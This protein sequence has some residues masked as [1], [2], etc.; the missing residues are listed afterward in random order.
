MDVQGYLLTLF[1]LTLMVS[2]VQLKEKN[3]NKRK[4]AKSSH[5][6]LIEPFSGQR[7][8]LGVNKNLRGYNEGLLEVYRGGKWGLVCDDDWDDQDADVACRQLGFTSGAKRPLYRDTADQFQQDNSSF[9]P[10]NVQWDSS[11]FVLNNVQCLGNE[12][13]L[14]SCPYSTSTECQISEAVS[15]TCVM[16]NTTD[17]GESSSGEW[18]AGENSCYMIKPIHK[19]D[20]LKK[21]L[22]ECAGQNGES[23][24]ALIET[25]AEH[26]FVSNILS[27]HQKDIDRV[28]LSSKLSKKKGSVWKWQK[29]TRKQDGKKKWKGKMEKKLVKM[30]YKKWFPGWNPT[31]FGAEPSKSNG[32]YQCMTLSNKYKQP[33]QR[34]SPVGFYYFDSAPCKPDRREKS[35]FICETPRQHKYSQSIRAGEEECYTDNGE[36]YRGTTAVTKDGTPCTRWTLSNYANP[37]T[38]PEKGLGDHKF[39]RNPDGDKEPWCWVKVGTNDFGFCDITQCDE[40]PVTT[41]TEAPKDCPDEEFYCYNHVKSREYTTECISESF[42]CDNEMDCDEE[43]DEL[44]CDYKL[45]LFKKTKYRVLKTN[46][47]E[48]YVKIALE[49]CARLCIESTSF[50]CRS[51]SYIGIQRECLLSDKNSNTASPSFSYTYDFYDLN[52][53][54]D[55]DCVGGYKCKNGRCVTSDSVCNGKDECLDLSDEDDCDQEDTIEVRLVGGEDKHSGRVEVNYRGEWGVICDDQWDIKDAIVV[56]RMLGYVHALSAFTRS[57]FGSGNG[58]FLL[59]EVNCFG[60]ETSLLSCDSNP[61][62]DH[63]CKDYEVAGVQCQ[64]SKGCNPDEF[65]CSNGNCV[66]HR[67]VCDSEDDCID[68][69]DEIDCELK[70]ELVNGSSSE[71]RV[72]IIRNGVR[73]TICDDKWDDNAATVVCQMLGYNTGVAKV[74][75]IYGPG[76]GMIW[77]DGMVCDG[78]ETSLDDCH[79]PGWGKHDC[80]HSEDAGVICTNVSIASTTTTEKPFLQ[81]TL[82][83][84][85][86]SSSVGRIVLYVGGIEGSICDDQFDDKDATVICRMIGYHSGRALN[87]T[88]GI[89][90]EGTGQIWIDELQ[91]SGT[92]TSIL[93]CGYTTIHD[94]IHSEDAGVICEEAPPADIQIELV[95]REPNEGRVEVTVNGTVGGICR[96][97]I[98]TSE[99]RTICLSLGYSEVDILTTTYS[100]N[101]KWLG[102]IHCLQNETSL[103]QCYSNLGQQPYWHETCDKFGAA[104]LSCTVS[105]TTTSTT[106][107]TTVQSMPESVTVQLI[108]G[109]SDKEGNVLLTYGDQTGTICDDLWD[110]DDATVICRMMGYSYGI[111]TNKSHFGIGT[112]EILLD[113]VECSGEEDSILKCPNEGWKN[114]DC[115]R[116][117]E[118]AG[119]KCSDEVTHVTLNV[120]VSLHDGSFEG[121]GRVEVT[122]GDETGS[123]CDD[124]WDY[125]DANVVCKMLG[126]SVGISVKNAGYGSS[127]GPILLDNVQCQGSES[128]IYDC[129][130]EG[131]GNSNCGHAEDAGVICGTERVTRQAKIELVGGKSQKEGRVEMIYGGVRGTLCS[132]QFDDTK[133]TIICKMLKFSAGK[134]LPTGKFSAGK[135]MIWAAENWECLGTEDRVDECSNFPGIQSSC[136]HTQDVGVY[137]DNEPV[138]T[139]TTTTTTEK[140]TTTEDTK[141]V[142]GIRVELVNG[143]APNRGRVEI[144]RNG[145]RGTV[146]DDRWDDNDATVICRML[147]YKRGGTAVSEAIYGEGSG[148]II[149]DDVE[150]DG[151]ETSIEDCTHSGWGVSNCHHT[152]DAGVR[153]IA[154]KETT[155]ADDWQDTFAPGCGKR[156]REDKH[157][158]KKRQ[159]PR[160]GEATV[161]ERPQ[162]A[163]IVYG[164]VAEYGMY[165]W[166][167]GV[168]K[169]YYYDYFSR[170]KISS[171]WCGGTIINKHWILSAAHC[172]DGVL[173]SKITIRTGD[174]NHKRPDDYEQEFDVEAILTHDQYDSDTYDND[175]ALVKISSDDGQG[176]TFNDYVQPAC[177]PDL[178]TLYRVGTLCHISGWGKTEHGVS[179]N[180]LRK[181]K[182][183]IMNTSKCRSLYK[184]DSITTHML[185]AGYEEG[186]VDTC[187]GDS[188]GP[189]VCQVNGRYTVLGV[190]SWGNGCGDAGAPGVYAHTRSLLPWI[191]DQLEK[192]NR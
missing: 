64:Q 63:D 43:E 171:V 166:Q 151:E 28:I 68:N 132:Q 24:L 22:K 14:L 70:I 5:E 40:A 87:N 187:Q 99:A 50:V 144:I 10:S 33:G 131:W 163:K 51:I 9:I 183:P 67:L 181:E 122:R 141:P 44:N 23:H 168:R 46:V 173:K 149:L 167:V 89:F 94:C 15:V 84:T 78:T 102:G 186:G 42:K 120:T 56:C 81:M 185:C 71:G 93:H 106:V 17:C 48:R 2:Y 169:I 95:G 140:P 158:R 30:S 156:S 27:R 31:Q 76:T 72:E 135:G 12:R 107:S 34:P 139:T 83:L 191:T 108:G 117:R 175:I 98:G 130:H 114:N 125:K 162:P 21:I 66:P 77:L 90:G 29:Y 54:L 96:D 143:N 8:R 82:N 65:T 134:V 161:R 182:I 26:Y 86:N 150:C 57:K 152:E 170:K 103:A 126:Y 49:Y 121:E 101:S 111:A 11:S 100:R 188:G 59:D 79:I 47:K 36:S 39:C 127:T 80:D 6:V 128:N 113:D 129:V 3:R 45:P 176:I 174:H 159:T 61:W 178:D 104:L 157:I 58:K 147:G 138:T 62:K 1:V 124:Y 37:W 116:V 192:Y 136:D 148:K 180:V 145:V 115:G 133:A 154:D 13:S 35:Y 73:G 74:D 142:S 25:E 146:C 55:V 97:D 91:C 16:Q 92:E 164:T 153:C 189:L 105:D 177:L 18:I 69:S 123:V 165:P 137:C 19:G 85:G 4:K 20:N 60:N 41:T 112:E 155:G 109:D 32:K 110:N 53:Q 88:V 75:S 119:V 184:H 52:S 179:P 172:F 160:L 118:I 190:T 7:I 38:H